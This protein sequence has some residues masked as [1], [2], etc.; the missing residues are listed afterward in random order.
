MHIHRGVKAALGKHIDQD[1][2]RRRIVEKRVL[3]I[4]MRA[5]R[6]RV[7]HHDGHHLF[8]D[9]GDHALKNIRLPNLVAVEAAHEILPGVQDD[10]AGHGQPAQALEGARVEF[11]RALVFELADDALAHALERGLRVDEVVVKDSLE[12]DEGIVRVLLEDAVAVARERLAEVGGPL[13]P[14]LA[15]A[16][17]GDLLVVRDHL[18]P[19]L[20]LPRDALGFVHEEHHDVK[21][22]L[23]E[24]DR[25]GRVGELAMQ[26]DHFVVKHLQALDLHLRAWEAIE[27]RAI[28]LL[29]LEELAQQDAHDLAVADHA[30][31]RLDLPRLGAVQEL[32]HHDRRRRDLPQLANEIR[33]RSLARARRAAQQDQLLR[34]AHSR[35]AMLRFEFLPNA[36]ENNLRVLDFEISRRGGSGGG[37]LDRGVQTN[38]NLAN[39]RARRRD[40]SPGCGWDRWSRLAV[41]AGTAGP[42]LPRSPARR[43]DWR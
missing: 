1:R 5:P 35:A 22:R 40:G 15:D 38:G 23:F 6:D 19:A 37:F 16:R 43:A 30:A 29:G 11:E 28:L 41:V 9:E 2:Q 33:V 8:L 25:L 31:L 7:A 24:M 32:A 20:E 13:L 21:D 12:R 42:G 27:H 17:A 4:N 39:A 34:K 36:V 26:R 3:G 18:A 10:L 14:C